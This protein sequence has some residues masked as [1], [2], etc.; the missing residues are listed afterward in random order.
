[1]HKGRVLFVDDEENMRIMMR[2]LLQKDGYEVDVAEDGSVAL[3]MYSKG[4]YDLVI[5]DIT[6]PGMNGLELLE[7]LKE[8]NPQVQV[9]IVTAHSTW[10]RAVEAM[11][12]GAYDYIKKPFDN[13]DLRAAVQRALQHSAAFGGDFA[14]SELSSFKLIGSSPAIKEIYSLVK[15]ISRSDSTVIIHGESGVGKEMIAR[16]IHYSSLRANRPLI[17]VNCGA[18]SE[19]LLESEL[20]GH[21]K[22]AFTGAVADKKGLLSVANGGS[23][24]MDELGEMPLSTQVRF[25]RVLENREVLPVGGTSIE[26]IDLRFITATNRNLEE[27]VKNGDFR[28]DLFYRLN[29]IPIYIPPLRERKEDIPLLA[30]HFLAVYAEKNKK[31]ISTFSTEAMSWMLD[32]NWEG[33]IRELDNAVQRAVTLC[34]G[35]EISIDDISHSLNNR[36]RGVVCSV[37]DVPGGKE[38]DESF[39]EDFCLDDKIIEIETNFIKKA[40]QE[41]GGNMTQAADLLGISFRQMR[42]KVKKL[43]IQI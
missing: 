29:V 31:N 34:S 28:E 24:F 11:R 26:K 19:T 18:F 16:M 32:R 23:F 35:G 3:S 36:C 4:K 1:M 6:M 7:K 17:T 10:E 38:K 30:G 8:I 13:N 42:Y 14:D 2:I 25:L 27:M 9:I 43:K 21:V 40:L 5:Q 20:F 22:G 39:G 33:N 37:G 41:S 12:L 15:R